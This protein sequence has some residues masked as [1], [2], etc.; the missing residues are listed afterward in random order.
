MRDES[1]FEEIIGILWIIAGMLVLPYNKLIAGCFLFKG[2]ADALCSV[3]IA[4]KYVRR[5]R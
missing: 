3:W 5:N 4:I 2:A 1:R